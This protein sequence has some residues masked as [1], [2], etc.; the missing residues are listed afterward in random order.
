[1]IGAAVALAFSGIAASVSATEPPAWLM[2][3]SEEESN[4]V[5][6]KYAE[7]LSPASGATVTAGTSVTFVAQSGF[8][9]PMTFMVASSAPTLSSPD[10]DSGPGTLMQPENRAEYA[11]ISSKAVATPRTIYWT[12]SFTRVLKG[13]EGP[14][15]TFTLAPRVLTVLPSRAEE[16]AAA[17][18]KAEEV[19][20]TKKAEEEAAAAGDVML[21]GT[22][23][24][25]QGAHKA[26]VK[27]TCA[28]IDTCSGTLTLFV[29]KATVRG[30]RKHIKTATVGTAAF[31]IAA[32][33]NATVGVALNQAGRALLRAAHG[34]LGAKLRIIRASP[35]PSKTQTRGV[36]LER[37]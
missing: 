23:I 1:M 2:C 24:K 27:L 15:V 20:A 4:K 25:I 26:L 19:A 9:S 16:A 14:P 11:F 29:N 34:Y 6:E 17:R 32:R 8:G 37:R 35:L 12:A 5:V 21:A 7:L 33:T 31:S 3:Q 36:H 13:C 22:A 30:G 28:D 10:I 18:V